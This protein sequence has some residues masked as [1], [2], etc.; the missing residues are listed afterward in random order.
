MFNKSR[1]MSLV[2]EFGGFQITREGPVP[3]E[4]PNRFIYAARSLRDKLSKMS[5]YVN[6]L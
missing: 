4:L 5:S 1:N 3:L 6:V 2:E